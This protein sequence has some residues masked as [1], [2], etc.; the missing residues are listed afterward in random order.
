VDQ[1]IERRIAGSAALFV[2][3]SENIESLHYTR[4]WIL[5][6]CG[7]SMNKEIWVLEPDESL[8]KIKVVVPRFNHYVR[9]ERTKAWRDYINYHRILY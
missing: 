9:Y 3:L 7:K 5:W 4:D 1:E 6:E 8:D 2:L